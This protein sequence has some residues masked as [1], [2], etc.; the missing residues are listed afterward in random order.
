MIALYNGRCMM[1]VLMDEEG[2]EA[3]RNGECTNRAEDICDS[4][5]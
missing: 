1:P 5:L 2:V 4:N 3:K